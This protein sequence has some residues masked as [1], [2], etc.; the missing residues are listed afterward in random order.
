M[1]AG[2]LYSRP[3]YQHLAPMLPTHQPDAPLSWIGR[4]LKPGVRLL[5]KR[6]LHQPDLATKRRQV[7]R[8]AVITM[9]LRGVRYEQ[10]ALGGVPCEW[11][12]AKNS[13][14][15]QVLLYLHGGGYVVGSPH[16]HRPITSRL[17]A[18]SGISVAALDYRLAPEHPFPAGLDDAVAAYRALLAAGHNPKQIAVGGDSAGGGL[19][20]ALVLKLR[21]LGLPQPAALLLFS[22]WTDVSM[23]GDS[24]RERADVEVML[25]PEFGQE[26]RAYY[27]PNGAF[28]QPLLSPLFADLQG[29]PPQL[30]QV[31]GLEILHSDSL[32]Y[33]AKAVAAG[34]ASQLEEW[35]ACWHVWQLHAGVM[36]E[37]DA[38]LKRSAAFLQQRLLAS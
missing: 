16:S 1:S 7:A 8:L 37:A 24:V 27:A 23:S 4:V 22:P 9:P 26:M 13:S 18:W 12:R 11:V 36:P 17:A 25:S 38:A 15:Q 5:V 10:E 20:I 33:H 34:V 6:A 14:A 31:G 2:L 19:S 3:Y 35:R 21:D 29:L 30:I 28:E 32:R